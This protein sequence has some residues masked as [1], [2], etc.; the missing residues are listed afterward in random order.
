M[1]FYNKRRH[2][3]IETDASGVDMGDQLLQSRDVM[4]CP[5]YKALHNSILKLIVFASK[6][7]SL[8]EKDTTI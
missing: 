7:L 2:L 6:V 4:N 8:V 3:Y 1:K 5:Q